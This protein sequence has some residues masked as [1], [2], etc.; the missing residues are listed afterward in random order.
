MSHYQILSK[1]A[2]GGMA[3]VYLA[4]DTNTGANV[5]IKVLKEEVSDKEKILERFAQEGLLNLNHPNIV[6]I[7]DAG[8]NENTPYIVMEY[9]EGVDLDEY[10]KANNPLS[11]D[12]AVSIYCQMLYAL[13]YIHK[14]GIIHRDIKPKNII[15]AKNGKSI[16]TDFGIAKSL[17][18]HIKTSTGGYLGAPAYSSPEQMDGAEVDARSDI[19]S[20][21]ITFYQMLSGKTPYSSTSIDVIIKEK[22]EGKHISIRSQRKDIPEYLE[23]IINKSISKSKSERYSSTDEILNYILSFQNPSYRFIGNQQKDNKTIV[24]EE[25]KMTDNKNQNQSYYPNKK[26]VDSL[27]IIFGIIA[28]VLLALVIMFGTKV[29]QKNTLISTIAKNQEQSGVSFRLYSD[30]INEKVASI[31]DINSQ[32]FYKIYFTPFDTPASNP[33]RVSSV[34]VSIVKDSNSIPDVILWSGHQ[35]VVPE[36]I[37]ALTADAKRYPRAFI[38]I[39]DSDESFTITKFEQT[40]NF[41]I[42]D[43]SFNNKSRD[44]FETLELEIKISQ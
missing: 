38:N 41:R 14:K 11:F 42:A 39:A 20:L 28:A 3:N 15:I 19:Y 25:S 22:F 27:T 21:G 43:C 24:K 36:N 37:D 29:L 18:S 30:G 35:F 16:L 5:A 26:R 23:N 33:D 9:I 1:L 2:S 4:L 6:K 8:V 17:Y 12:D 44:Y 34:H 7:L 32:R 40:F 13:S 10:I 31:L